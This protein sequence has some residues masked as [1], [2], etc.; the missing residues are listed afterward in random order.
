MY[1]SALLIL[2]YANYKFCPCYKAIFTYVLVLFSKE[3]VAPFFFKDRRTVPTRPTKRTDRR[4]NN[5]ATELSNIT[6]NT[7]M[8]ENDLCK[9]D[10]A[11]QSPDFR[12]L[13]VDYA[14]EVSDPANKAI[15]EQEVAQA[16]RER[17][18]EVTF[19]H[20][21]PGYVLK[22][23]NLRTDEKVFVNVCADPNVDRPASVKVG[24]SVRWS[25]PYLQA[26]PRRDLDKSGRPCTV[27][28]VVFHPEALALTR[29]GGQRLKQMVTDT[30]LDAVEGQ[31]K[32][33]LG[34]DNLRFPKMAFKGAFRT[35]VIRRPAKVDGDDGLDGQGQKE[36]N[37]NNSNNTNNH[38]KAIEDTAC[39]EPKYV[40]KYRQTLDDLPE[41]AEQSRRGGRVSDPCRPSHVVVEVCL[42]D[43][44]STK[45]MDLDVTETQ[46]SLSSEQGYSLR[47]PFAYA[48]C[49]DEATAKFDLGAR[50]LTVVVPVRPAEVKR[51]T[52]TDSGI[53]VDTGYFASPEDNADSVKEGYIA[54]IREEQEADK[55]LLFPPYSCNI[56]EDLMI[57]TMDVRRIE[58]SSVRKSSMPDEAFGFSLNFDSVGKGM[59]P[60]RYAFHCAMVVPEG[61]ATGPLPDAAERVEV[62][63]WDNNVIVKVA[64]P[65]AGID[66]RQ[67]KVGSSASDLTIHNLPQLRALRKKKEDKMKVFCI[68]KLT[69]S[70][71]VRIVECVRTNVPVVPITYSTLSTYAV[72]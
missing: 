32:V 24:G 11:L 63:V 61:A 14:R 9:L 72:L 50:Q 31:F 10:K 51:L 26:D 4:K 19:L 69:S 62:E 48:V 53:D 33:K 44:T 37:S 1:N 60:F 15:Y 6:E 20:P 12:K 25:V 59:V 55:D 23:A 39:R 21:T 71:I 49:E 40:V 22:T 27:Y 47:V 52:S 64:L 36:N 68:S 41:G 56:Y 66:F 70:F 42:P 30:A 3:K 28:D 65:N 46:L 38:V 13:L 43:L 17:G 35:T 67:Y 57:F 54:D 18:F 7:I 34:R 8:S 2:N 45:G 5:M 16:E 58:E 29:T